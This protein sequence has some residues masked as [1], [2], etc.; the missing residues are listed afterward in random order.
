MLPTRKDM[1]GH[2]SDMHTHGPPPRILVTYKEAAAALALSPSMI[3]K[4]VRDGRLK[5]KKFGRSSRIPVT[6][7]DRAADGIR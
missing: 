3:R 2:K 5:A 6:E 7:L 4:M 1:A